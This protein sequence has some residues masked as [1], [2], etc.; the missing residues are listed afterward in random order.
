[1]AVG[2]IHQVTVVQELHSQTVLNVF[3]YRITAVGVGNADA[4][5]LAAFLA[6]PWTQMKTALSDELEFV[7]NISQRILPSPPLVGVDDPTA[8]GNGDVAGGSLPT[9]VAAVVTKRTANAGR[10]YR[11]RTFLAGV[12][13]S[14]EEDSKIANAFMGLYQNIASALDNI[15][16]QGA[17]LFQPVLLHRDDNTTTD[18]NSC[19]A[20]DVLRNQRRRQVGK[21]V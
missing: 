19:I 6:G 8:S 20:R 17:W 16:N 21:G 9:S 10:R 2:D 3:H 7:K 4:N 13:I 18:I 1:M 15:L 5:L 12:P 11:G 14:H